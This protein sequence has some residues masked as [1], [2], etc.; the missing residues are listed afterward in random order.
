[1]TWARDSLIF[2]ED[3]FLEHFGVHSKIEGKVPVRPLHPHVMAS[4]TVNMPHQ[5]GTS[6]ITDKPA[7]TRH[8]HPNP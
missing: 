3:N 5:R 8:H 2:F 6:V 4:P 7:V 1:M